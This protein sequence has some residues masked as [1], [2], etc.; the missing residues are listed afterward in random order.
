MADFVPPEGFTPFAVKESFAAI[1]GP[2]FVAED[3]RRVGMFAERRHANIAGA[4]HGGALATLADMA[5]FVIAGDN[6]EGVFPAVTLTLN[7]TFVAAGKTGR[8]L[9]AQGRVVKAGRSIVFIDGEIAD[10]GDVLMTF[11][12]TLKRVRLP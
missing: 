9:V 3:P 2:F 12:G 4:V 6:D 10:D 11:S 5:L 8:F 7:T 1:A